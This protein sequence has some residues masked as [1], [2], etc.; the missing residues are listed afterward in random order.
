MEHLVLDYGSLVSIL[1]YGRYGRTDGPAHQNEFL[2][3]G[4]EDRLNIAHF[5]FIMRSAQR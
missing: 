4:P 1:F 5:E 3:I 2:M